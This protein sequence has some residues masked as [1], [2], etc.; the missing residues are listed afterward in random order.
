VSQAEAEQVFFNEP[1]LIVADVLRIRT[2]KAAHRDTGDRDEHHR[3][4][5]VGNKVPQDLREK[6]ASDCAK[7]VFA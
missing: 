6:L 2:F 5:G 4:A 1:L 3:V 7:G